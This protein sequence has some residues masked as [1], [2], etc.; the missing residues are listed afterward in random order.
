MLRLAVTVLSVLAIATQGLVVADD[1][2]AHPAG[3]VAP[4]IAT[5][6]PVTSGVLLNEF[7]NGD[8]A[9][10][11]DSFVEL[12][13]W[14]SAPVDL[15]GWHVFPCSA[16]GLRNNNGD[17]IGQLDGVVLKPGQLFTIGTAA[18]E[19]DTHFNQA[20]GLTGFG[21][22]LEGPQ[23]QL[24]DA[25]GVYPNQPWLT[26]SDCTVDG[27]NL[28]NT[29]DFA[30]NESFQ[31]VAATGDPERDYLVAPSTRGTANLAPA[32]PRSKSG[33]VISE[34]A[35][36]GPTGAGDDFIEL[37]N[38]G[39]KAT[40]LSGWQLFRCAPSGRLRSDSLQLT[41]ADGTVLAAGATWLAAGPGFSGAGRVDARSSAG[42]SNKEFGAML[43][44]ASGQLVDRVA[45]SD[46]DDSACQDDGT[47]LAATADFPSGESYQRTG[48]GFIVAPRTPGRANAGV[49]KS[50]AGTPFAYPATPG[51]AISEFADDPSTDGM[52]AGSRQR[53]YVELGNYGAKPVDI[54][55]W[56][57]RRCEADGTRAFDPQFT[58]PRGT[59]LKA[60]T[61]FLAALEGTDAA[62]QA[63]AD[64]PTA[65]NFLGTGV[66]LADARGT[67]IDSLGVFAKNEMDASRVTPSPCTQG[68]ALVTF[69]P[70]RLL[71]QTF[72]R[73][74]FTGSNADDF[75]VATATPGTIDHLV[76]ADPTQR[77][78]GLSLARAVGRVADPSG[79]KTAALRRAAAS[80]EHALTVRE[81][82]AGATENGPL[83]TETGGGE[84]SRDPANP[85]SVGDAGYGYPY[86]RLAV[87]GGLTSGSTVSWTG[88]TL[89]RQELQLSV[90]NPA[91]QKWRLLAAGTGPASVTLSGTLTDGEA[92]DGRAELLVQDGPRTVAT[93][94]SGRDGR[95]DD[96]DDYDLA[97]SHL[98][99]TQY[100]TESYPAVYGQ[101]V[102]W[103]A[104]NAPARK[105]DFATH[106]GDIVQ[107][108]VD[109]DQ[110]PLRARR[111]FA[112]ASKMQAIL[113]D[114][115]VPNSVLPGN[116]DSKRGNDYSL[117]NEYFPPSRYQGNGAYAGSIAPDDNTANFSTFESSGAKF[118]MLSLPYAFGERE[119]VWAEQVVTSHPDHNVIISTHEHLT[120]KTKDAP[121]Y[122]SET[123]R[124]VSHADDLWKRVIAPNRNVI[125]VLSGHFHGVGQLTTKDAG[126]IPGHNVVE[127]VADYQ[128]FRTGTGDRATGFQ[129]LLQLDLAS[130]TVAVDTFSV[131]L[132]AHSSFPYD[133]NQ[134]LPDNGQPDTMSNER[135]WRIIAA[136]TQDRY[137]ASDDEFHAAVSFE[138]QKSLTMTGLTAFTPPSV[139]AVPGGL[140]GTGKGAGL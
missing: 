117:F 122:R 136:G 74:G 52:P 2:S 88:S 84:T 89:D 6:D 99:D 51:V 16:L 36:A 83:Q 103:I 43:R 68:I 115:G 39:A 97:I 92:L 98:T 100:L 85:G 107:N 111:E 60:G 119:M 45:V 112:T 132:D 17:N 139:S 127:L 130:S 31:R 47:K 13:N 109:P 108:W 73:V 65:F 110:D 28:P 9:S 33:V 41:I 113:D 91:A 50:L 80:P 131:A 37:R 3:A 62:A 70:D 44:T 137:D 72:Q 34:L 19:A 69:L 134:F 53:N 54:G 27:A 1:A 133:Y 126:G 61:T 76:A 59:V 8:A 118:L 135:P 129:R 67:R 11:G 71:K 48:S 18:L 26:E 101:E 114:A 140:P 56:T 49:E 57:V 22:Y 14:G 102:S 105:I 77:V 42:L 64:Y 116:H 32:E 29:L 7:A 124:W 81:A 66:W 75:A 95:L 38:D 63:A 79:T 78:L 24:V 106:T 25:V 21:L 55:G 15:T 87:E 12:R 120:P 35:G 125:M 58:V 121:A 46:Y 93:L 90:W 128:E 40:D 23:K 86:L 5:V 4:T 94:A 104:D 123:S 30:R 10:D 82:W 20:L 96:P 138:Y